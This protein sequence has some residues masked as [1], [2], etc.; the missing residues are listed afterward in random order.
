MYTVAGLGISTDVPFKATAG[1]IKAEKGRDTNPTKEQR[2]LPH[3][4]TKFVI[5]SGGH[6]DNV[7]NLSIGT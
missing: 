6:A 1:Q 5:L 4:L 7:P 2:P 3:P